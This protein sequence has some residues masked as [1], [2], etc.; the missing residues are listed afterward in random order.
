VVRNISS[1]RRVSRFFSHPFTS[2]Q[3]LALL[4]RNIDITGG[5]G[6]APF[7]TTASNNPSSYYYSPALGNESTTSDPGWQAFDQTSASNWA[8]GQGIRVLVRGSK[9]QSG[10][11]TGGVYTPNATTIGMSGTVNTGSQ[12]INLTKGTSSGFNLVGNPYPSPLNIMTALGAASNISGTG[13]YV[14]NPQAG[15]KGS[16]ETKLISGSY[17]LPVCG[18]FFVKVTANSSL[19]FNEADKASSATQALSKTTGVAYEYIKLD[20]ESDSAHWDGYYHLVSPSATDSFDALDAIKFGNPD[21]NLYSMAGTKQAAIDAR[22]FTDSLVVPLMLRN[23]GIRSYK[24]K[25][26]EYTLAPNHTIFLRDRYTGSYTL[27]NDTTAYAF[28]VTTDSL[29]QGANR[30]ELVHQLKVVTPPPATGT[31]VV[32]APKQFSLVPNPTEGV[33]KISWDNI[34]AASATLRI[35]DM[36][37]RELMRKEASG[38]ETILNMQ[39]LPSG[40]YFISIQS[41]SFKATQRII[42]N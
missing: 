12:T 23:A 5:T 15:T 6:A 30:F 34:A 24:L 27:L 29:T 16:Y 22:P 42:K 4:T 9:G 1:G 14:W 36:A 37:G 13:I 33:V 7:T 38:G 39:S 8:K 11:L 19:T 26:A 32:T 40:A 28:A 17:N 35:T 20:V 10:S 21:L 41:G 31:G 18:A 3:S 25:V 2:T